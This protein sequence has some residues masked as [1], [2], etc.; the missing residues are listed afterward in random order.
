MWCSTMSGLRSSSAGATEPPNSIASSGR[1][2]SPTRATGTSTV[3][4]SQG[5]CIAA[6]RWVSAPLLDP[7]SIARRAASPPGCARTAQDHDRCHARRAATTTWRRSRC[8]AGA[9]RVVRRTREPPARAQQSRGPNQSCVPRLPLYPQ[10]ES[11]ES[12]VAP[13][14]SVQIRDGGRSAP[15]EDAIKVW[16][17]ASRGSP[18]DPPCARPRNCCAPAASPHTTPAVRT[19]RLGCDA[20]C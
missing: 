20:H 16:V 14:Y 6:L 9:A 7:S 15:G 1:S 2:V 18:G 12:A 13:C 3:S 17:G 5:T 10:T 4:G 8:P 19:S 11:P